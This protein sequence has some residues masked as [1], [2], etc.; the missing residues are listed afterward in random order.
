M[1]RSMKQEDLGANTARGDGIP[2]R[3][4]GLTKRFRSGV[5]AV[6]GLDLTVFS[7]DV[8]GLLGPNGAGKTTTLRMIMGLVH[9]T[10]GSV[11]LFGEPLQPGAGVLRRVGALV[12]GPGFVPHL[13]G[14]AN[15]EQWW[16]YGG[17]ELSASNIDEALAIAGLGDAIDRKYKTY[18][19][20]MRQRLG[21]AQAMLGKPDLLVLDEPTT[22]LDP[23]QMVEIRSMIRSISASGVTVL[24]SS[25]LLAEV[26]QVCTRAAIMNRG[27][28]VSTGTVE[29]LTAAANIV[30]FEVDDVVLAERVLAGSPGV[31]AVRRDDPGLSVELIDVD[32]SKIVSVLVSAG[33][34]VRTVMARN[35]LEDAFLEMLGAQPPSESVSQVGPMMPPQVLAAGGSAQES[36]R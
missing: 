5:L 9:P 16:R 27:R 21:V 28:L 30:Y 31:R 6:D 8:F 2:I 25:H 36:T 34:A 13:S 20:G 19:S 18:S 14:M 10:A 26:E 24:L 23:Q 4:R 15:L 3:I 35:R 1:L 22:G 29:E 7:G 32:R 12:E 17:S 11:E 33:V